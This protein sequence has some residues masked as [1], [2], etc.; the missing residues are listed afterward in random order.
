MTVRLR[1]ASLL[2][3][4]VLASVAGA[5]QAQTVVGDVTAVLRWAYGTPPGAD[6]RDLFVGNDVVYRELLQTVEDG[7]LHVHLADETE[8]RLGSAS[9]VKLDEFV[10]D[11]AAGAGTLVATVA[12]GVARF[13]TG[14]TGKG[15]FVVETPVAVVIPRGTEFSV[16]VEAD[17]STVIWVQEGSVEVRP[18]EGTA[19]IVNETEIVR[20]ATPSSEVERDAPRPAGDPGMRDTP[21]LRLKSGR[22]G[23]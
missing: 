6:R 1:A 11:P 9:S 20:V 12:E 10:Y 4:L 23:K 3:G 19:A 22:I 8:V 15:R 18:R 14:A 17:G 5:A 7:A 16:W 21:Q 2:A 13:I